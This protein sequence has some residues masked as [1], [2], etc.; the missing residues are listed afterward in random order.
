MQHREEGKSL[1]YLKLNPAHMGDHFWSFDSMVVPFAGRRYVIR[2][3][4]KPTTMN[5]NVQD[6]INGVYFY[7]AVRE[8]RWPKG[9]LSL[10]RIKMPDLAGICRVSPPANGMHVRVIENT[11]MISLERC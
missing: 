5:P 9:I 6:L 10:L 8:M 2:T 7:Q 1:G 3:I 4:N 11:L